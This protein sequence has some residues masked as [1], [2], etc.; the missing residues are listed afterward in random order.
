MKKAFLPI[1]IILCLSLMATQCD[2]D[3]ASFTQ[4]DEQNELLLLKKEIETLANRS[5]CNESTACKYIGFGSKPCGGP[6]EYLVYSTSIDTQNL[7]A[8]VAD[9]NEQEKTFNTKWGVI[10]DC[11]IPNPPASLKCENNICIAIY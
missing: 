3:Q 11:A 6:W 1:I 10:S 7:E 5:V 4:V 8:L 2:E 9:Y